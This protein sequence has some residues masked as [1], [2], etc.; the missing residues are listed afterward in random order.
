MISPHFASST[1]SF[2]V[3]APKSSGD[4]ARSDSNDA[5]NSP[6]SSS[7]FSQVLAGYSKSDEDSSNRAPAKATKD[8]GDSDGKSA[9]DPTAAA[10]VQPTPPPAPLTITGL[11][12]LLQQQPQK[13]A[14]GADKTGDSSA[15]P[16]H[17]DA[18]QEKAPPNGSVV[19]S[20]PLTA[21]VVLPVGTTKAAPKA[22]DSKT[23]PKM[24]APQMPLAFASP[25]EIVRAPGETDNAANQNAPDQNAVNQGNL[26]ATAGA[27]TSALAQQSG[28][29]TAANGAA[30]VA[31]H[32]PLAFSML[33]S[34]DSQNAAAASPQTAAG[35]PDV[36]ALAADV[37][38]I[39]SALATAAAAVEAAP[40]IA[41]EHSSDA[42]SNTMAAPLVQSE[43]ARS[44]DDRVTPVQSSS[45]TSAADVDSGAGASRNDSVRN[46][47]L[48]LDG[49]NN[50]RVDV[51]LTEQGGELRVNVRSADANLTQ[52]MQ[53]HM[54]DLTNRLG[55]QHFRTEVWLPRSSQTSNSDASNT[56]GSQSQAGDASGQQNSGRRQ[57]GRQN[58]QQDWQN[59]DIPG[60]T[61]TK[62]MN[63]IWQA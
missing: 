2:A 57:N 30:A 56:R 54:P 41:A 49:D 17:A 33:V 3:S 14:Q 16:A 15:D 10:V 51:R 61:N 26:E 39:S 55:Q 20:L 43:T 62:E 60:Q 22:G 29:T 12:G 6:S 8:P 48:Q 23:P 34:P 35:S 21:T 36:P 5:K 37:P 27:V 28:N 18:S 9:D 59:E 52:A 1:P 58:N 47:R 53:D 38:H 46:V 19:K 63:Q 11:L 32:A 50:Q 31:A 13:D 4:A 24:P 42:P 25:V 45:A 44:S 40:G 7:S